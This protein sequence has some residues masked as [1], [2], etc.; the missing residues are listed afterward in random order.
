VIIHCAFNAS[1][2]VSSETLPSY[3]NDNVVL[4]EQ[5][6]HIPH[7]QFIFMSSVDVYPAQNK[8]YSENE[9]LDVR[10]AT[11]MYAVTK[12]MS[13]SL[14]LEKAQKP[15][16]L[17]AS[18]LLGPYSRTNSL[19]RIIEQDPCTLTLA[20]ESVMNYVRYSDVTDFITLAID[21]GLEGIYNVTS[22]SNIAL[23]EVVKLVGR[24]VHFGSFRYQVG[25][26]N[27]QKV[28]ALCPLFNRSSSEIV[29]E[30]IQEWSKQK[31]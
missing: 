25:K 20:P 1:R 17:R 13:E 23:S 22:L 16:V 12:L 26:I 30:F 24:P 3:L 6:I 8:E 2:D 21:R 28:R 31:K 5:L 7:K 9:A 15:L 27:N 29:Q 11:S 10:S 19:I 18:A 4:T 14:V